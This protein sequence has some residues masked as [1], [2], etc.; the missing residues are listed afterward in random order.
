MR[1]TGHSSIRS[2]FWV[3]QLLLF[4]CTCFAAE[5]TR[6]P[7]NAAARAEPQSKGSPSSH[8]QA[9]PSDDEFSAVLVKDA[10]GWKAGREASS[11]QLREDLMVTV[12]NL[13]TLWAQARCTT[14]ER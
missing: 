10:A 4:A 9:C 11:V 7:P 3:L 12:E 5:G 1:E 14:P 13:S 8:R 6:P 2:A